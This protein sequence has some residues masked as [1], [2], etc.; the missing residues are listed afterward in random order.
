MY[1]FGLEII[2]ENS[3]TIWPVYP[4]IIKILVCN[5]GGQAKR[6]AELHEKQYHIWTFSRNRRS[7]GVMASQTTENPE[8]SMPKVAKLRLC[9]LL[10]TSDAADE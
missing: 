6:L 5:C 2:A 9:C 7:N 8:G 3:G 4:G 10:Y 1:K